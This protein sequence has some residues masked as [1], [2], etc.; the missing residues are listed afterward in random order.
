MLGC[1]VLQ[2]LAKYEIDTHNIVINQVIYPDTGV[3]V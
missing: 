1:A 2:E 3:E